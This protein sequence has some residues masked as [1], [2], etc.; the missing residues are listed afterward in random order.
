MLG[1]RPRLCRWDLLDEPDA[2]LARFELTGEVERTRGRTGMRPAQV[3]TPATT[4]G[5]RPRRGDVIR[6]PLDIGL[7]A[8]F[9]ACVAME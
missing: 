4:D 9:E 2:R 5:E 1:P 7:E 6:L 3:G 8:E